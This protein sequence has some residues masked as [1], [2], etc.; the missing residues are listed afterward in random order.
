[1]GN[2]FGDTQPE[3]L[4]HHD[5][6]HEG[7]GTHKSHDEDNGRDHDDDEYINLRFAGQYHDAESGLHYNYF[8]YYDQSTGRYVTSDPIGLDGGLNTFG[9]VGGNPNRN[10]DLLGLN[11]CDV[12]VASNLIS[13]TF[14]DL[15]FPNVT[16]SFSLPR[17]V[18]GR[19]I[20]GT[21]VLPAY[22]ISATLSPSQFRQLVNTLYHETLHANDT[23][24]GSAENYWGDKWDS[25]T[26]G[27]GL[28]AHHLDIWEKADI[29]TESNKEKI[30]R[31][32]DETS[33]ECGCEK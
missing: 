7:K 22:Q 28:G 11:L 18:D 24:L 20:D 30:D 32:Y 14:P 9:Y 25:A 16:Y 10:I 8:R 19:I 21:I 31:L 23:V 29:F 26:G 3:W 4:D 13:D 27:F 1:M 33:G 12:Q 2:A 15:D 5:E 17:G 6:H